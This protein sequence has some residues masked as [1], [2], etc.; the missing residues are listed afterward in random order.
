MLRRQ[1]GRATLTVTVLVVVLIG[2]AALFVRLV[3]TLLTLTWLIA[4]LVLTGL[5]GLLSGL[6][7]LLA[8][9]LHIVCHENLQ[10]KARAA[11]RLENFIKKLEFSCFER[12][13]RLGKYSLLPISRFTCGMISEWPFPRGMLFRVRKAICSASALPAGAYITTTIATLTPG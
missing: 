7:T 11:S 13:Q 1:L 10:S 12:W 2:L 8:L 5:S 9:L 3:L 6:T 4:L